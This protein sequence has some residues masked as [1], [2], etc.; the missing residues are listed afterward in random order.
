MMN[1]GSTRLLQCLKMDMSENTEVTLHTYKYSVIEH[2]LI[3][4]S[5]LYHNIRF[6]LVQTRCYGTYMYIQ[7][8]PLI[9]KYLKYNN[10]LH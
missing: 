10:T 8:V 7:C 9:D 3:P 6:M 4:L 1:S 2:V 5:K